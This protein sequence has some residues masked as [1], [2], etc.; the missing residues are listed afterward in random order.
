MEEFY[1]AIENGE[2]VDVIYIDFIRAFDT[3]PISRLLK[4]INEAGINGKIY[5][6]IKNF[7]TCRNYN[8]KICKTL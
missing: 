1:S 2:K 4:K 6:F 3:V 8:V 7:L 5:D